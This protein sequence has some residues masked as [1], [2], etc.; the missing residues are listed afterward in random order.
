MKLTLCLRDQEHD[1][2]LSFFNGYVQLNRK[3]CLIFEYIFFVI[4]S[5]YGQKRIN[6]EYSMQ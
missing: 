2:I 6:V 4:S 1:H 5:K 3:L